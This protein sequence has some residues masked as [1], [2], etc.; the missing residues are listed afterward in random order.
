M[1]EVQLS[2]KLVND[3]ISDIFKAFFVGLSPNQQ[4]NVT[5]AHNFDLI[6]TI[7]INIS[8]II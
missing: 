5:C 2:L 4:Q 8:S 7:N 6:V 3:C 1:D